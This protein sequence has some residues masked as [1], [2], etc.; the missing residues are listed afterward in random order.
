VEF[1]K[2]AK[3]RAETHVEQESEDE[4]VDR[5]QRAKPSL[6]ANLA[7]LE[8]KDDKED[9]QDI[10]K[11]EVEIAEGGSKRGRHK[12]R[13]RRESKEVQEEEEE[14]QEQAKRT[15][16]EKEAAAT[17]TPAL[18]WPLHL[19]PQRSN[20]RNLASVTCQFSG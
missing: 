15:T 14:G 16:T 18:S 3:L 5:P 19:V 6:F 20:C 9:E 8:N 12:P 17:T 7:A 10:D 2:E 11:E 4:S 1:K 13:L